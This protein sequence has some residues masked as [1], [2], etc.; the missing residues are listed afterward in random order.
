MKG[1]MI[2]GRWGLGV[3]CLAVS[4]AAA[5][6]VSQPVGV[7]VGTSIEADNTLNLTS[8]T[9]GGSAFTLDGLLNIEVTDFA[10]ATTIPFETALGGTVDAPAAGAELPAVGERAALLE[11]LALNTTLNNPSVDTG[12]VFRFVDAAGTPTPLVNNPGADLVVFE[13]SPPAGVTPPSGGPTVLGGDPFTLA[14][15][16]GGLGRTASFDADDYVQIGP[17]GFASDISFFGPSPGDDPVASLTDL[18]SAALVSL[19]TFSL[20]L[21]AAAVDLSD[22]GFAP[23]DEVL[24]FSLT[25]VGPSG[26][27][28]DPSL[29]V[30]LVPEPSGLTLVAGLGLMA[31]GVRRRRGGQA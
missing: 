29:I 31:S 14:A 13:I 17:N 9:V 26:F 11:D 23:G 25:S 5:T 18:E 27:G 19:G 10:V 16:V 2:G 1:L 24:A 30:G 15:L 8:L 12:L 22:L 4:G 21:Y 6:A 20:N 7:E 28:A 3:A